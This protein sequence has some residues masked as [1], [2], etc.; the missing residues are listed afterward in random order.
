MTGGNRAS[1]HV[2]LCV[3]YGGIPITGLVLEVSG[4]G[5]STHPCNERLVALTR[6]FIGEGAS[7]GY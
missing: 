2:T 6:C 3:P 1:F 7:V 4:M 5:V